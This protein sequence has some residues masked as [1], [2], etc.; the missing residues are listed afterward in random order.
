MMPTSALRRVLTAPTPKALR[1]LRSDLLERGRPPDAH[2]F[3]IIGEFHRYL[4][5]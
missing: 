2:V 1:D 4:D 3:E 5:G